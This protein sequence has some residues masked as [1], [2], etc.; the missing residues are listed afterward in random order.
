MNNPPSRRR[1]R[2]LILIALVP[3]VVFVAFA[4]Y[5]A[6]VSGNLPWQVDPTR[7]SVQITP[8]SDIPGSNPPALVP[9]TAATP[10]K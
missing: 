4:I 3:I 8:F 9:K 6:G 10:A 7:V 2:I 5:L 1:R